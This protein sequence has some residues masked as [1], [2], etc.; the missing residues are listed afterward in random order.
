[1]HSKNL[2][3]TLSSTSPQRFIDFDFFFQN[4]ISNCE[5]FISICSSSSARINNYNWFNKSN[6]LS[7]RMQRKEKREI[8]R[9]ENSRNSNCPLYQRTNGSEDWS[10][11]K[12]IDRMWF[13][14]ILHIFY[15]IQPQ[16]YRAHKFNTW[17]WH[18]NNC[19]DSW[20]HSFTFGE[21]IYCS[22]HRNHS[23]ETDTLVHLQL[24]DEINKHA[25]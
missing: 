12:L 7:A 10:N 2:F 5:I 8:T 24:L 9:K 15:C 11:Y 19:N 1:M 13:A 6:A 3:W 18:W 23:V 22:Y 20:K 25:D 14:S 17:H 4:E 21:Y 16:I